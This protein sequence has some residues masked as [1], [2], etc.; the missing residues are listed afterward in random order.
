[1]REYG[2]PEWALE[3]LGAPPRRRHRWMWI[4]VWA[5]AMVGGIGALV[6]LVLHAAP[7]VGAAGGCGGA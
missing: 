6:F 5:V 2:T 7:A 4:L 1:M 3:G